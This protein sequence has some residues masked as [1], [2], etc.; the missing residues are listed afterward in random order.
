MIRLSPRRDR[1][2]VARHGVGGGELV[3]E[4]WWW[5]GGWTRRAASR[6]PPSFEPNHQ[7]RLQSEEASHTLYNRNVFCNT[8]ALL[9]IPPGYLLWSN[10][11]IEHEREG[12]VPYAA[13]TGAPQLRSQR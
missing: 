5:Y 8:T 1:P 11:A 10:V 13:P 7:A 9:L 2:G 3:V 12:E 4:S 6:Q